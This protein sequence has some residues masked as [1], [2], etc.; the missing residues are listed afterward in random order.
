[1]VIAPASEA[2]RQAIITGDEVI[3]RLLNPAASAR[4]IVSPSTSPMQMFLMKLFFLN[5]YLF[6]EINDAAF[7]DV[8]SFQHLLLIDY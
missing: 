8:N 2:A 6:T 4:G 7:D 5:Y 3:I 1:M